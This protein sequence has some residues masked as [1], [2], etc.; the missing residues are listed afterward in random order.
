M[1]LFSSSRR[2]RRERTVYFPWERRGVLG[3]LDLP[4][5]RAGGWVLAVLCVLGFVWLRN[6]DHARK[7]TRITRASLD[8]ASTA[9]DAYRA[10]HNG[11]C[12]RDLVEL[13]APSDHAAYLSSVPTDAWRRPLRFS[14]PARDPLYPYDLSSDGPDGLPYGLDRIE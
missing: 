5:R 8:R 9:V 12:P 10:D 2:R 1:A 14:C 11:R 7:M 6:H 13:T 3:A 4:R